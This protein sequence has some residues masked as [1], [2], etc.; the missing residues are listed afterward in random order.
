MLQWI[1]NNH[2]SFILSE[3]AAF[4]DRVKDIERDPFLHDSQVSLRTVIQF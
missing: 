1:V 3:N 4:G 2:L